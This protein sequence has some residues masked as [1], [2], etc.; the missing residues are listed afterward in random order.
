M[1]IPKP[2]TAVIVAT[3]EERSLKVARSQPNFHDMMALA[4]TLLQTGFLPEAIKTPGQALAII[5]TGQ[6]LGLGP[7]QSLRSIHI[8]KGKPELA[9]DLQ[10]ALFHRKDAEGKCGLSRWERLDETEAILWLKHPNGTEHTEHFTLKDAE[11]AGLSGGE[12]YKKWPK[13]MLRSRAITAGLKSVGFEPTTGVYDEGEISGIPTAADLSAMP[14]VLAKP[15]PAAP[16]EGTEV[17]TLASEEEKTIVLAD[18]ARAGL[19]KESFPE[20]YATITGRPWRHLYTEDVKALLAE[21]AKRIAKKRQ[22]K[23][24]APA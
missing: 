16:W 23:E 3:A 19:T 5:L 1:T 15:E 21:F 24:A 2:E 17:L 12:N 6:E 7:M 9:A 14:P 8:I 20:A 22:P 13:A 11:R 18:A 4:T 10:L